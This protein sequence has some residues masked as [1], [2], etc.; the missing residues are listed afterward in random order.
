M[1]Y[2]RGSYHVSRGGRRGGRN[3]R[4]GDCFTGIC[5]KTN[6]LDEKGEISKCTIYESIFH[7]ANKCLDSSKKLD[8]MTEIQILN[9]FLICDS[10]N[11]ARCI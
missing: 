2:S 11:L 6:P 9:M 5:Q 10:M 4:G 7:W 8:Q 3:P 1:Y